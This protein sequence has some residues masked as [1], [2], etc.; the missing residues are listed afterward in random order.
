MTYDIITTEGLNAKADDCDPQAM[1]I[2]GMRVLFGNNVDS[3][4][5]EAID[6][7]STAGSMGYA[8]AQRQMGWCYQNGLFVEK[9]PEYGFEWIKMAADQG[10]P[11]GIWM[12]S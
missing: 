8:K 12:L 1:Y 4:T 11:M 2:K 9:D 3:K 10:D 7:I 5:A 6:Y